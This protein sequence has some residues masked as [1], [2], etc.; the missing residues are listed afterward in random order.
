MNLNEVVVENTTDDANAARL[1][2]DG[3]IIR[4][5]EGCGIVLR[6]NAEADIK[7]TYICGMGNYGIDV[8]HDPTPAPTPKM[9]VHG[10]AT[11]F[12]LRGVQI[13]RDQGDPFGRPG[14][15][16]FGDQVT[17]PTPALRNPGRNAFAMNGTNKENFA[18][19]DV[20]G[21]ADRF[22]EGN[23]WEHCGTT[24]GCSIT[25]IKNKDVTETGGGVDVNPAQAHRNPEGNGV[26]GTF[27]IESASP[28]KVTQRGAI[29]TI[30]GTNFNAVDGYQSRTPTPGV[31]GATDCESLADGNKC[32]PLQ[33]V[34]VEFKDDSGPWIPADDVLAVTPTTIVVK[35][36]IACSKATSI[37]VSR[38]VNAGFTTQVELVNGFCSN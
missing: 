36:S 27:S 37:R 5:T 7:N 32:S 22:T 15:I 11:A 16:N 38:Q 13:H 6:E 24:N 19:G 26:G 20:A 33:G 10:T 30:V 29:V 1:E 18:Y 3:D 25:N 21:G 8:N 23:Q 9:N 17:N 34:C 31:A 12:N 14:N 4:N 2:T 35:S 28:K